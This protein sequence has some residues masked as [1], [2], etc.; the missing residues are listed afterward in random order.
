VPV[1]LGPDCENSLR[2][3][4]F[5]AP[6]AVPAAVDP[7]AVVPPAVDP[8]AVDPQAV[9]PPAVVPPAVVPPAVVPPAVALAL[10]P[11]PGAGLTAGVVA[12]EPFF[13]CAARN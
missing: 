4:P 3:E 9:V 12:T 6:A 5:E 7:T 13:D 10:A 1:L 8:A 11:A 2:A